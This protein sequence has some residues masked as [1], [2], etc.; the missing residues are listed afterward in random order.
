MTCRK[1]QYERQ[2]QKKW[3][4]RKNLTKQDWR[5]LHFKVSKR[6]SKGKRTKVFVDGR[7]QQMEKLEHEVSR[8]G[9][10]KSVSR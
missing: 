6:Q 10:A 4:F 8:Y 3:R 5:I 2:F 7:P 9:L 1:K